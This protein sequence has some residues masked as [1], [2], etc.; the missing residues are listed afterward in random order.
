MTV[1]GNTFN[2]IVFVSLV[3]SVFSVLS[4]L[5][6]KVLHIALPLWVGV[7]GIGLYLIPLIVPTLWL[8]S[9]EKASWIYGY[10][11]ACVIWLIGVISFGLYFI[12]RSILARRALE[13]YHI[14]GDER[15]NQVYNDCMAI[16]GLKKTPALYF[17]T[18]NEPACV[19]TIF[20]PAVILNEAIV[21]QLTDQEL[22]IVL[23]HELTHVQRGHH[24]YQRLFDFASIIHWFNPFVWISKYD[25]AMHCEMDCDQ[26]VLSIMKNTITDV[27]YA[28]SMLRLMELSSYQRRNTTEGIKALGFLL[29]KQRMGFILN[30]PATGRQIIGVVVLTLFLALTVSFSVYASRSHFYPYPAFDT[31]PEY[32]AYS[33]SY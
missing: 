32:A 2:I 16:S 1:L 8:V 4:L 18:L 9:P 33:D 28:T 24:I 25:F 20:H 29:A 3:G 13:K 26:K 7:C 17:G 15:I 30:P 19:V 14:C 6:K 23:C 11:V 12:L 10:Q 22:E 31:A 21:K 5:A 27:E